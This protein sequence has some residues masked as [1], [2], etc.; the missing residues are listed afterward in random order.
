M[1]YL[2][3]GKHSKVFNAERI[4]RIFILG[5]ELQL[6]VYNNG[7]TFKISQLIVGLIQRFVLGRKVTL[8]TLWTY[9]HHLR[10]LFI[11][12]HPEVVYIYM[13]LQN[14]VRHLSIVSFHMS[15]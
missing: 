6:C 14:R 3:K 5:E 15:T 13:S 1:Y 2:R 8:R 11:E 7:S 12:W 4:V 9:E 10:L